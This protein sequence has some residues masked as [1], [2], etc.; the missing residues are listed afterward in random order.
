VERSGPDSLAFDRLIPAL[1]ARL[2]G[3]T[4]PG[5]EAHLTM[6]PSDR[7]DRFLLSVERKTC[8]EAAVL[9]LLY[10]SDDGQTHLLLTARPDGLR[11]H[12]GQIA[13]PGGRREDGEAFEQTA[14]R[15]TWEE[16]GIA[17]ERIERVG[18]LTPIYIPPTRFCCYP[19][20]GA[21]DRL[22]PLTLQPEEVARV[23]HVPL[24]LLLNPATRAVGRWEV[25]GEAQDVPLYRLPGGDVWGATAMM[26]AELLAVV[27]EP[28]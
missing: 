2:A 24:E 20:V 1:R 9:A 11:D 8:R 15:E 5:H 19:F 7:L 14:L 6:A 18:A 25:R 26:L 23:L 22:P 13:F 12:A 28:R 3:G 21:V 16:V 4:L 17:P 27:R 10:P